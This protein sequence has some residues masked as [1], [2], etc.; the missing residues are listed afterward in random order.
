MT[1]YVLSR[2]DVNPV[3]VL[4]SSNTHMLSYS[5]CDTASMRCGFRLVRPYKSSLKTAKHLSA[6]V[7]RCIFYSSRFSAG[8][9]HAAFSDSS[10][11]T[12]STWPVRGNK[13]NGV[14]SLKV[15]PFFSNSAQSRARVAGLHEM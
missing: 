10:K 3:S 7:F 9:S 6:E 1:F 12:V 5:P 14:A 15:Y 4:A 13:S 8:L 11:A 2:W